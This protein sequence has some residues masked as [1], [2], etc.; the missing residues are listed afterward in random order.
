MNIVVLAGGL[1]MERDVSLASGSLIAN[2]LLESGHSAVLVDLYYGIEDEKM[3]FEN[4]NGRY[5][6]KIPEVAPDLETIIASNGGR[7]NPIGKN[8]IEFCKTADVVF[9]ALHGGV[10]ENGKLQALLE[11]NNIKFTGSSS[12]GCML[13]MD[14]IIS[15]ELVAFDGIPTAQWLTNKDDRDSLETLIPC[16]VKP[17]DNG[18]SVGVTKVV[19]ADELENALSEA[20]KFS[21][22]VLVEKQV[23]GRE[24]SVGVIDGRALPPIEI[25]ATGDFYNYK[26]KYQAGLAREICPAP[27]SEELTKKLQSYAE[28]AHKALRLGSYSRIDFIL[29]KDSDEFFFLEANAL[30]GMTPTSLL[31][32]EAQADGMNYNELCLKLIELAD[33]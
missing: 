18:S 27:L 24:F 11:M 17:S 26:V 7:R 31:P 23:V 10:G 15:K 29:E 30:P 2:S 19:N 20:E 12:I 8:V 13:S 3:T 4:T 28:R 21:E 9:L 16:F 6:Y 5:E 32:Q 1:S 22:N 33:K 25:I 14:K